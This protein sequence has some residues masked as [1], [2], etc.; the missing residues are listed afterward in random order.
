MWGPAA[1]MDEKLGEA[2]KRRVGHPLWCAKAPGNQVAQFP[3]RHRENRIGNFCALVERQQ[4]ANSGLAKGSIHHVL[5]HGIGLGVPDSTS[6][7]ELVA[8]ELNVAGDELPL[9]LGRRISAMTS[10]SPQ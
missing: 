6:G 5:G 1:Q 7:L 2:N 3:S 8:M 10:K 9:R 4:L